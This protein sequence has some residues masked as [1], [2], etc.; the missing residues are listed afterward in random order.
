MSYEYKEINDAEVIIYDADAK[1]IGAN[2]KN[3]TQ[4]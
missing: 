2:T 1:F 4:I 3:V